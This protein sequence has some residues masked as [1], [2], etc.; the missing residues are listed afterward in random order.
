[1]IA[2]VGEVMFLL[3][4]GCSCCSLEGSKWAKKCV[5]GNDYY[6]G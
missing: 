4:A 2:S 1:M 5:S 3:I 6:Q